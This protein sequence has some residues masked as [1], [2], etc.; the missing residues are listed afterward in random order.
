MNIRSTRSSLALELSTDEP[1]EMLHH[2]RTTHFYSTAQDDM[3]QVYSPADLSNQESIVE[4]KGK[5]RH[6]V[7]FSQRVRSYSCWQFLN[8]GDLDSFALK[9]AVQGIED[10]VTER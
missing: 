1:A 2:R 8:Y 10:A 7:D 4:K 9:S 5:P 3:S 6:F